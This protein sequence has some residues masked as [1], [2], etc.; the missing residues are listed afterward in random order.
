[1][2]QKGERRRE[3]ILRATLRRDRRPRRRRRDPP[4]RGRGG[5][6][7]AVGHHLL[8]RLEGRAA[9]ADAACWPRAR[10]P[11][12]SSGWCST[13]PRCRCPRRDWAAAVA[14]QIAADVA[15]GARPRTSR[16]SSSGWRPRAPSS[17]GASSQR[18]QEA[19]I[20]LAEM[21]CRAVGSSEPEL[22]ARIVVAALTGL[23]LEQLASG[24]GR[25]RGTRCCARRSSGCSPAS[26]RASAHSRCSLAS[27]PEF[28]GNGIPGGR[29]GRRPGRADAAR[30]PRVVVHVARAAR[31]RR[32]RRAGT[33]SRPTCRASATPRRTRPAR[34]ST[35]WSTSSACARA[36]LSTTVVLVVHDW[37]GLIGLRW[38]CEHPGHVRALVI[39]AVGLLPRRQVARDGARPARG[40]HRR[41]AAWTT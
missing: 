14:A 12:G 34:G 23:M 5:R 6:R 25:L 30:L 8:L 31:R 13:W 24:S 26:R 18:W 3:E 17:C 29:P 36:W 35:T 32:R 39:S 33:P 21:G 22:D 28:A 38:A 19:H 37:G 27:V 7:A 40:G 10:R 15:R 41:A 2:Y 4:R 1:M 20:R 9:R 11:S 16:C